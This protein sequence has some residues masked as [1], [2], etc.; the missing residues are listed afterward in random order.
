MI[1]AI[2]LAAAIATA[3]LPQS[4]LDSPS[5]SAATW[6]CATRRLCSQIATCE[7]AQWYLRQCQ[8]GGKLDADHDGIPCETLC[9]QSP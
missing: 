7:E 2:V 6:S 4:Q 1:A 8:W 9:G 3:P 5:T